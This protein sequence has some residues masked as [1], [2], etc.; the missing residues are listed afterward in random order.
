MLDCFKF[1]SARSRIWSDLSG[2]HPLRG[3]FFV[4]QLGVFNIDLELN[5]LKNVGVYWVL[6]LGDDAAIMFSILCRCSASA[7]L[8]SF[9]RN[10]A[11]LERSGGDC[12]SRSRS[13]QLLGEKRLQ[14]SLWTL[15][16]LKP[17]SL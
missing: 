3:A 7:S 8:I 12:L 6:P 4:F 5:R 17:H 11:E 15:S 13:G 9:S 16:Q 1:V 10:F 14:P 2:G